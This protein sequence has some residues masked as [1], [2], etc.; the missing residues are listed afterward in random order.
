MH[1]TGEARR[2]EKSTGPT[3][4]G[5]L[6]KIATNLQIEKHPAWSA[7]RLQKYEVL[8]Q[9][10]LASLS[11]REK[12]PIQV[13]LPDGSQKEGVSWQTTPLDIAKSI[14]HK[15]AE[16]A[17]VAR[18][19]YT[20]DHQGAEQ[21]FSGEIEDESHHH[22]ED[23]KSQLYD[24]FRP[25][26]G[27]CHLEILTW[28]DDNAKTVFWHSSS[29]ILGASLE[30]NFGALLTNGPPLK[31]GYYYDSYTGERAI[32]P[33]D[34]KE[35]QKK[36]DE[37]VSG[38][39]PF[40][41][42]LL[43][44]EEALDLFDYNPFKV[45]LMRVKLPENS[46]T[47]IY[48][49]GPF[50]DLCTGPHLPHTGYVKASSITKNSSAYFLNN[51]END[52]LQRVYGISF[53]IKKE[54]D[55]YIKFQEEAAQRDHRRVGT[56]QELYFWHPYSPGSTFFTK[57]GTRIYN[58]LIEFIRAEYAVRGF[59]EVGTPNM[60]SS[61]L[62]K[63]S[64]HYQNYKDAMFMLDVEN[65]EFGLKPMNCPG[66]CLVFDSVLRSYRELPLRV[67]EFG[68]L[69]RNELSG[70]LTG[71]FRV[72]R[73]VQDDSHI[74]IRKD[75]IASEVENCLDFLCYVYDV[76]GF[77]YE[78]E[79]STK[80]GK[81]LG[82]DELWADAE[83]QLALALD[84]SGKQWKL[85]PGDGAFYGPKIDIQVYDALKRKHQC[86]TIQL[87]FN[88][89]IRFDLQ[90]K[91]DHV[92]QEEQQHLVEYADLKEK[93]VKPG[94]ERP[95]IIHR[96]ILGS[97]E[98]MIGILVEQ[99][100]GKWPFWLSP[101]QI[102]ILPISDTYNEY[103]E[104]I[105]NRLTLEG[106]YADV[107]SDSLSLK[108]KVREAQLAQYNLIGV[109]GEQESANGTIDVRDRDSNKSIGKFT[110]ADF[111]VYMR[112]LLPPPSKA[113]VELERH[114]YCQECVEVKQVINFVD[115]N[116]QLELQTYIKG[117]SVSEEDWKIYGSLK[118]APSQEK[119]PH[120]YRWY[121]HLKS[122]TA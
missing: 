2:A 59:I 117:D 20:H 30:D 122:I 58:R 9:K 112:S 75:Q 96:A 12:H 18:I 118:S 29:H 55:E 5:P 19:R 110:I 91:T 104:Q 26:E 87:D 34:F 52:S 43:T 85:N 40:E 44:K 74:F 121:L 10:Y 90:F 120:L 71:L 54:L 39:H 35:I 33:E 107:N 76:F 95:V 94:Y 109:V 17:V 69:H 32:K 116:K 50:I 68:V 8:K 108:K 41:R 93:P 101:R 82:S 99:T 60:F 11:S 97:L 66:H 46:L 36:F 114:S 92:S 63:T 38:K 67:A 79:L 57:H 113:R 27:D 56:T 23:E 14:S 64:G 45:A 102:A 31:P 89:P 47:S 111:I 73:F 84:K 25:L 88:L 106:F 98:R 100:G 61:N 24:M 51:S 15:L 115:L 21:V 105:K 6:G 48:R 62:W 4:E 65:Q 3:I 72:R 13:T 80:P 22:E 83:A 7:V 49:C 78:F 77:H 37:L 53:P 42:I 103:A 28:D 81:A 119:Y 86:G 70:T 16:K 1:S